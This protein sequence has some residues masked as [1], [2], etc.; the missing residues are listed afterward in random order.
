M[1]RNAASALPPSWPTRSISTNPGTASSHCAQA[2]IGIASFSTD[3][4][5]LWL[6]PRNVSPAR[7]GASRR[8]IVAADIAVNAPAT[9]SPDVQLPETPQRGHQLT[10]HRREPLT[11]RRAEHRPTELQRDHVLPILGNPWPRDP[12]HQR[13]P[14]RPTGMVTMPARHRA[15]LVQDRAPLRPVRT[16]VPSRD[17]LGHCLSLAHSQSHHRDL[18]AAR[19]PARQA[20]CTRAFLNESTNRWPRR[21]S[22]KF[23]C[24][25]AVIAGSQAGFRGNTHNLGWIEDADGAPDRQGGCRPVAVG[26]AFEVVVAHLAA[27]DAGVGA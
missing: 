20:R 8:S 26:G 6:R 27:Y 11:R 18:P 5:L 23:N 15:Q 10:Q 13:P 3:P 1:M 4:G 25:L 16:L 7:S 24:N 14:Q 22:A 19:T 2:R 21:K 12:G 9:S 17:R